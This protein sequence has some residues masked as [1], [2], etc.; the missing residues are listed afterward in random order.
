MQKP[1]LLRYTCFVRNPDETRIEISLLSVPGSGVHAPQARY[2][3][4]RIAA[5]LGELMEYWVVRG[6]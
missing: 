5:K 6:R 3:G 4:F 2:R 1:L